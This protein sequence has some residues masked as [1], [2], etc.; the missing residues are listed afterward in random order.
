[1]KQ[2]TV[3]YT[4]SNLRA[5]EPHTEGYENFNVAGESIMTSHTESM[6]EL[7]KKSLEIENFTVATPIHEALFYV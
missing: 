7:Q 4:S 6:F 5:T 3:A 2:K 1:M